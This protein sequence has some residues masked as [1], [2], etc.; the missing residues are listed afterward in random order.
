MSDKYQETSQNHEDILR[1]FDKESDYR[2]LSGFSAKIVAAI[3]IAFSVFH[4]YTAVCG[5]L[6]AM[7]QRSIHLSFGLC[8]IFLLYP[9]RKE[10]PRNKVHPVDVVFAILGAAVPMYI[11]IFYQDLVLR[12]GT[13]TTMDYVVG[14]IAILLV[15]E[16]ARRVVGWPIVTI[17][18]LFILYALFGRQ[19]PGQLAHRGIALPSLVGH[20]FY[21]TEGIFGIP[22]GVSSTFIFLFILFGAF[23]EKTGMGEFFIDLANA[24][25]GWASGGPAKVA[26]LSSGLMGTVSGSS[27]ANV[28]GTGSFTIPMMKRL[29]YKPEF[30]GAVEATASTGGQL[31]PPIM[32]AAAFLMS[33]FTQISYVKII[34]AAVIPA[35]LYYFGVWTGVHLEAKRLG[36]KGLNKDELPKIKTILLERGHLLL[37]LVAIIYLLVKGFS[38]MKAALFAIISSIVASLLRKNTRI[39]LADIING[40]EQGARSALGVIAATACAGIIIGVV[41]QTGLGLKMG[42]TLVGLAK[43]NLLLTLFFTMLTSIILGMGVPTTANYVITSTIAAPALLMMNVPVLA[44]HMFVFYFGIIADIT[45]PVALAAFAGAGIAKANPLKTGL[46][47]SKLAIAAFLVPYIFVYNPSMLLI[48]VTA[49]GIIQIIITSIIGIIGVG[50]A[51]AGY[52]ITDESFIERIIFF[53]GGILLVTPGLKTDLAGLVLLI[54]GYI[55]QQRKISKHVVNDSEN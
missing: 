33:E 34:G 12:A 27:V 19:I 38:P 26:V 1:K 18:S 24:V 54:L 32:G 39:S 14:L 20:L 55:M 11:I 31:M 15:L 23:L 6:D 42:S 3:A 52:L 40:L 46:E 30:A 5:V 45:P 21:T 36:L 13:V 22:I 2:V 50:S 4:L 53:I 49:W 41:T 28:V 16:A 35:L 9:A 25:A 47:A 44:A 17:A 7:I 51:V 10:W 29:G 8:L 43:G 37:P 48:D